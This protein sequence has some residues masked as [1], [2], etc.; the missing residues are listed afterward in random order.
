M[1]DYFITTC[2][3]IGTAAVPVQWPACF[4]RYVDDQLE[5]ALFHRC[6]VNKFVSLSASKPYYYNDII[7][8]LKAGWRVD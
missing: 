4:K 1:D 2:A 7:S 8:M 3:L 6:G 5:T